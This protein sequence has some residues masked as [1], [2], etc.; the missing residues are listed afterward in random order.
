MVLSRLKLRLY[1]AKVNLGYDSPDYLDLYNVSRDRMHRNIP[2]GTVSRLCQFAGE[3]YLSSFDDYVE[4]R[5]SLGLTW[6]I[7]SV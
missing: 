5:K 6:G 1:S 2:R 3:L 4:L 7:A